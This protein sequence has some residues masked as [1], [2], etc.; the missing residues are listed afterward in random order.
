MAGHYSDAG[1]PAPADASTARHEATRGGC[2]AALVDV[3]MPG[4]S[5]IELCRWLRDQPTTAALP[6]MMV[7]AD[8]STA[9][10]QE[11]FAA[12]ADDYLTKPHT[13]EQ[14][15]DRMQHLLAEPGLPA[16]HH[17]A[18]VLETLPCVP[19]TVT[20]RGDDETQGGAAY[21]DRAGRRAG[22]RCRG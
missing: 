15:A 13:R 3:R 10:M 7:S 8:C 2:D 4:C 9:Q 21:R 14:L 11:A 22:S 6:I 1:T 5:G 16:H 19:A 20:T 12:G 18:G 17:G